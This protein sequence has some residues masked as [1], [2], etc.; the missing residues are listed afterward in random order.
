MSLSKTLYPLLSTGSNQEDLSRH[1]RKIVD[2]DVK[3]K[4][5]QT[6]QVSNDKN[7]SLAVFTNR[8]ISS[9][10]IS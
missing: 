5:K 6:K 3:N 2:W 1:N 10:H 8:F 4:I 7:K 9:H